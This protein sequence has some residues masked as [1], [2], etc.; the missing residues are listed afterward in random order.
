MRVMTRSVLAFIAAGNAILNGACTSAATHPAIS[1]TQLALLRADSAVFE[2]IVRIKSPEN[3]EDHPH[4]IFHLRINSDPNGHAS[5]FG[6][7]A[8]G[9]RGSVSGIDSVRDSV[10]MMLVS[11][12]R[13]AIL[14]KLD[15]EEG[16]PFRY[17]L[18]GGTLAPSAVTPLPTDCPQ[19]I[20][21]YITISLPSLG[22]PP[23]L[24]PG[25]PNKPPPDLS[26]EI[27][28]VI[29]SEAYASPG[30]QNW[31]EY[32]WLL[33]RDP[34]DHKLALAHTVLLEWVE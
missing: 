18:C 11:Q 32:A 21:Y 14:K 15:I 34:S 33:R 20:H 17:S 4:Q 29:V 9:S 16:G 10:T 5:A 30:G 23:N 25:A 3:R 8:G 27:W 31:F 12:Q 13:K 2:T 6:A 24:P 19:E 26:G 22:V 28:T 7:M 1:A